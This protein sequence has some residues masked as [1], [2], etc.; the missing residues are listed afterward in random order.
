MDVSHFRRVRQGGQGHAQHAG[1]IAL[2]KQV[3]LAQ[4]ERRQVAR[5]ILRLLLVQGHGAWNIAV[6][7]G[8]HRRH[9]D[10]L[11]RAGGRCLAQCLVDKRAR[12]YP[13]GWRLGKH[14]Q[15]SAI[16]LHYGA[17]LGVGNRQDV[18]RTRFAGDK[19]FNEVIQRSQAGRVFQMDRVAQAVAQHTAYQCDTVNAAPGGSGQGLCVSRSSSNAR[20]TCN[21]PKSSKRCPAIC[22][23][24]GRPDRV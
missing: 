13:T 17:V 4:F 15:G 1:C 3:V 2:V 6:D 5:K 7:P 22:S 8:R 19:S 21:T 14:V 11:A 20:A 10:L 9:E 18:D 24:I 23:P 12:V 16:R